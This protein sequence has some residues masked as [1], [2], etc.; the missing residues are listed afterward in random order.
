MMFSYVY[1]AVALLV[2]IAVFVAGRKEPFWVLVPT[3]TVVSLFWAPIGILLTLALIDDLA[4]G[5]R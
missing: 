2:A 1:A 5:H 4:R 3:A